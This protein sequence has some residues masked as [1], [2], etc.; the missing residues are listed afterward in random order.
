MTKPGCNRVTPHGASVMRL[1]ARQGHSV[2]EIS[3]AVCVPKSTV[4]YWLRHKTASKNELLEPKTPVYRRRKARDIGLRQRLVAK[5][6]K[7]TVVRAGKVRPKHCT[8]ASIAKELVLAHGIQV[9]RWTV[10][11]DLR[12]RGFSPRVRAYVPTTAVDDHTRRL[13]FVRSR[14]TRNAY[15]R[16]VFTDEKVFTTNDYGS[17]IQWVPKGVHPLGREH[18]RFPPR[19]MIWAAIGPNFIAWKVLSNPDLLTGGTNERK[20]SSLTAQ[21]YIDTCLPLIVPFLRRNKL[22]LQQ[23]GAKPHTAKLTR[24]YLDRKSV[25]VLEQ[26]P[27]RSPDLN[28][29]ETLW[30]I[31]QRRV[32]DHFATTYD[33]LVTAVETE[34]RRIRDEN[35][36]VVNSLCY[37]FPKR[38]RKTFAKQGAV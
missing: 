4:R 23:D 31:L 24:A 19:V 1:L 3:D 17:R 34:L 10:Q 27:A 26:W 37:S 9:S 25:E 36:D 32:S 21:L 2:S 16:I 38:C 33:E 20:L 22:V 12:E 14:A 8:A 18:T 13:R 35:I 7:Q 11:R 15:H 28:P 29:I 30:A 6:A 5:I